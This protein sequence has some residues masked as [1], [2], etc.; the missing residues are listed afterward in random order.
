MLRLIKFLNQIILSLLDIILKKIVDT[1]KYTLIKKLWDL[2]YFNV[3]KTI[4][5]F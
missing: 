4:T 3:G 1:T 5:N 2:W